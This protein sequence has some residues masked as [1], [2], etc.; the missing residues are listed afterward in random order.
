M[1]DLASAH[2]DLPVVIIGAGPV[3]LAAAAHVRERGLTPVVLEAGD[4]VAAAIRTWGHTR[5]FSPWRY[6]I[7][8]A[9]RRLLEPNGWQEPDLDALP[10]GHELVDDYLTPLSA[11][12]GHVI[13]TST[14]VVAVSR[15]GIDKTRSQN[16]DNTP[17]LVRIAQTD[18]SYDDVQARSVI[19][20]SGTWEQ[21]NPL[22]RSGLPAPGEAEAAARGLITQPLPAVTD[23]HRDRFAGRHILVIGAGHSAANT[24]L[25]LAE[26]AQDAPETRISWAVRSADV[27]GV[28]G[29]EDR[30]ELAARGALGSRLRA[31]VESGVIDVHTTFTISGFEAAGDQLR[32]LATGSAGPEELRVDLLVPA[33]GFRPDLS[34]LAELRLELDPAVEA[35]R[36][37]GPLIDP[38]FHSCGSV[39]PHGE[40]VLSHP[41]AGFYIVGMKSYGRAPTF[42]MATGYEQVRSIAAAMAGDRAAADEVHLNLPETGVCSTDLGGSC[43]APAEPQLVTIG[44][45]A[46]ASCC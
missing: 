34:M 23:A 35:P 5:L 37:L 13:R 41:E 11:A 7:D 10:T 32:V 25:D 46:A 8:E 28:Y 15:Q 18:G 9:A 17:F 4:T 12:L 3:G 26:L 1:R 31:L 20:A 21:P 42:L 27:T 30:D 33:T 6:N 43:D 24:L 19:D 39:E 29:G 38:E 40:S 2:Q 22:G 45:P 14:R 44:A 16:R 36:Q